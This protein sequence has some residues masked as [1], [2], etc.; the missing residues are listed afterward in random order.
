MANGEVRVLPFR[1]GTRQRLKQV[2]SAQSISGLAGETT[3]LLDRVGMLNYL[4]VVLRATVNLTAAGVFATLGP[5]SIFDRIRVEL[6]LGN[7]TLVDVSGWQLY[8]INKQLFRSWGPDGAGVYAASTDTFAAGVAM[9]NNS[10]IL[11]LIIPISASPGSEF[12]TGLINLQ[13]PEVSC[14]VLVRLAAS[15]ATFVTNFNT[16]T[17]V[18]AEIHQVY[19]DLPLPG[20]PIQL[21]LGQIVRTVETSKPVS[22]V[23]ELDYT[24]E[25][26]GQLFSFVS[27]FIANGVRS[28]GLD[29]VK[30]IA[31]INDTIYD[32]V[33]AVARFK[34]QYD[35]SAPADT[36]V[37][38]LD[39][40]H[41]RESPSS[42]D[43]RDIL[44]TEVL[45]TLQWNPVVSSGTV[46]GSGNNFW[47]STRRVLVNFAM[48]GIGP[49]I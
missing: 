19:F 3:F 22:A 2:K 26:Q 34:N 35:I 12:D 30:L 8:Q 20:A 44:N 42:G 45:T 49:S 21:P 1:A 15:G 24:V 43:G 47:N 25:R 17:N 33:S 48:P 32:E 6:N 28:N 27:T 11:P 10:W 23:G 39:L 36:G 46:L 37:Y 31:N 13:A 38:V 5:W 40:W 14:N 41:A 7:M 16:L 4:I 29:R 9:G 18:T